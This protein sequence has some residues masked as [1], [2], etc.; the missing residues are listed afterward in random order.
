MA[1]RR[2]K[3]TGTKLLD[4]TPQA[5]GKDRAGYYTLIAE[6]IT[7]EED[8][9]PNGQKENPMDRGHRLEG[10]AIDKLEEDLGKKFCRDLVIWTRDDEKRIASSP[11]AYTEDLTEAAE[12][13]CINSG[14]HVEAILTGEAPKKYYFQ[15]LQY[16]IVNDDLQKLHVVMYDPRFIVQP[17]LRFTFTREELANDIAKYLEVERRRLEQIDEIV[18]KLSN[19]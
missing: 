5:N 14:E 6:M 1:A 11:D 18:L 12:A 10:D 16:F 13:K 7:K 9:L 17:Y 2:G 19:F 15:F 4:V 8:L 3:I